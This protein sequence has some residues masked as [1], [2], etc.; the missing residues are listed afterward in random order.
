MAAHGV[1]A[2]SVDINI[3][4]PAEAVYALLTHLPTLADLAEETTA[5]QWAA[6]SGAHPG[7]VFRGTN[8]NDGHTWTTTCTVTTANPGVAFAWDVT[9]GPVRIAHWRY[10]IDARAGGCRVTESMW[11]D[12]PWWLKRIGHRLTGIADRQAPNT[13][14]IRVTLERLKARAEARA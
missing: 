6:G 10:E 4:A 1:P 12:R 7:A 9:S 14:H 11:D 8:R 2:I 5:M 3:D 13:Q